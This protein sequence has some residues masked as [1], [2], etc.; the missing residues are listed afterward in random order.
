MQRAARTL[1]PRLRFLMST[2]PPFSLPGTVRAAE[3][4]ISSHAAVPAGTAPRQAPLGLGSV[5]A[6]RG[7]AGWGQGQRRARA[8]M[9]I[10]LLHCCAGQPRP[11]GLVAPQVGQP[12]RRQAAQ[13]CGA[14]TQ[15]AGVHHGAQRHRLGPALLQRALAAV[16]DLEQL[17]GGGGAARARGGRMVSRAGCTRCRSMQALRR[18]LC[19]RTEIT[20]CGCCAH[21]I[22]PG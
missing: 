7:R 19:Y 8:R 21:P 2:L 16:P 11:R 3:P 14:L 1:Q 20:S 9:H 15:G 22:R 17:L 10:S 4:A 18:S 6:G 5:A 12:A 13:Q